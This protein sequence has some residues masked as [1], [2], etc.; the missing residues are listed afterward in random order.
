MEVHVVAVVSMRHVED[1]PEQQM[2]PQILKMGLSHLCPL[3][4]LIAASFRCNVMLK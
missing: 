1:R 4:M 3:W 2:I